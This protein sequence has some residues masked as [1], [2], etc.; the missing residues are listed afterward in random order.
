MQV[1]QVEIARIWAPGL[2]EALDPEGS[3]DPE[4]PPV[5]LGPVDEDGEHELIDGFHRVRAARADGLSKIWAIIVTP[6]ELDR[7]VIMSEPDWIRWIQEEAEAAAEA[8]A[9]A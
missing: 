1:T 3:L 2:P 7:L 9:E 6:K 8:E 5:I 4:Y